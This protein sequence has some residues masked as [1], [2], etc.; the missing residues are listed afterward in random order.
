MSQF[1]EN[2]QAYKRNSNGSSSFVTNTYMK[3]QIFKTFEDNIL[4]QSRQEA[5]IFDQS[6]VYLS[7]SMNEINK[8]QL[9]SEWHLMGEG[10]YSI[11]AAFGLLPQLHKA[12]FLA[13]PEFFL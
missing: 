2:L 13:I 7:L 4:S 9:L 11:E 3:T 10:Q 8:T 1:Q 12:S 5:N 6:A